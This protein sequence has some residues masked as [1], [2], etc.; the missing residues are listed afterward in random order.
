MSLMLQRQS[1]LLIL[2]MLWQAPSVES[3]FAVSFYIPI[4]FP[5]CFPSLFYAFAGGATKVFIMSFA[6]QLLAYDGIQV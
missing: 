3:I 6:L 2:D 4:L 5:L 1:S